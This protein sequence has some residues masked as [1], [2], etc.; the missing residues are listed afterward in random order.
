MS[1]KFRFRSLW[2]ALVSRLIFSCHE[3]TRLESMSLDGA[4]SPLTRIRILLHYFYCA[5]CRRYGEQLRLLRRALRLEGARREETKES[6]TLSPG[7]RARLERA[8]REAQDG[9]H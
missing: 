7:F 8:V 4:L 6:A 9:E 5:W 1:D 3:V 2:A